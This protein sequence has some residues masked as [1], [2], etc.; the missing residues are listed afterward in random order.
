[1]DH[2]RLTII[3][4]SSH[5]NRKNAT[6]LPSLTLLCG[7]LFNQQLLAEG[8]NG[9]DIFSSFGDEN[10]VSIATGRKQALKRAPAVASVITAEDIR[11]M[12]ARDLDEVLETVPGL[13]VSTNHSGY[14][15]IYVI[16][17]IHSEFNPQVLMLVNGIPITNLFVGDRGQ[18]W[19]GF[20]LESVLR[21]EVIRGPGSAIYGADAYAGTINIITKSADP[22]NNDVD[23][24]V[25]YG[26][27]DEKRSWITAQHISDSGFE[28]FASLEYMDTD[29]PDETI[30]ADG[31]TS[32]DALFAPLPGVSLAPGD[33]ELRRETW[34]SRLE[35]KKDLVK[36]RLG[37]QERNNIG[38]GA[39]V[40][41]ILDPDGEANAKRINGDLTYH[42]PNFS[43]NWDVQTQLSYF[44]TEAHSDLVLA[45]PGANF[46]FGTFTEG[47]LGQPSVYERHARIE[48]SG[49]YSGFDNHEVRVG[50]G[51][52]HLDQYKIE[53]SKN[54]EILPGGF[55]VPLPGGLQDV[56]ETNPFNVEK[57]RRIS[58]LFLQDEWSVAPD[59]S[60]TMGLRYDDYSDFGSTVNPRLAIVWQTSYSLTSKFLYGRAFRAPSYSELF[61]LNNP[62]AVGNPDLDPEVIDTYEV[63][64]NYN[65]GPQLNV[66][67]NL[68]YYEMEDIIRFNPFVAENAG[69][70]TG[71]GLEFEVNWKPHDKLLI[72]GNFAWQ[73]S[74][75]GN[76]DSDAPNA[77]GKQLYV[78]ANYEF[79]PGWYSNLQVNRVM[80]RERAPTDTRNTVDDYTKV[81]LVLRATQLLPTWELTVG[82]KN[83]TDEEIYEPS[84]AAPLNIEGDLPQASRNYFAEVRKSF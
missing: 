5:F 6:L 3:S 49:F 34:D 23:A 30:E 68:F 17:G 50:T 73:K 14:N 75:D 44:Q 32:L 10:F 4:I 15:P 13:H 24:G 48:V 83:L 66:G 59:W 7:L 63:A 46:G 19:G 64:F 40:N 72:A 38:L 55:I 2:H 18:V 33:T 16:R 26:S 69:D 58:Y 53:E 29:G 37:Y 9:E 70:Q 54:F 62:V 61:N 21:V 8:K 31:Q 80:D 81:D 74:E 35:V 76:T 22:E 12:G 71:H 36:L 20:P 11:A 60:V 51:Y 52:Q 28:V 79:L 39:G 47:V 42:D 41:Q 27:Y 1:M 84:L 45:P 82:V 57:A 78:Q 56:T 43:A 65:A 77:P 25:S 67:L